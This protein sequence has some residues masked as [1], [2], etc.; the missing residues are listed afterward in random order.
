MEDPEGYEAFLKALGYRESGGNYQLVNTLGY[1]GAY[2][3]G[4]EALADIGYYIPD[5]TPANDWIGR[6]TGKHGVRSWSDFLARGDAQDKAMNEWAAKLWSYAVHPE[7]SLQRY[8]GRKVAGV[9]ISEA[10]IIAGA[11]LVGMSGVAAFLNSGG[12]QDPA[13]P[14]GVNVSAYVTRFAGYKTPFRTPAPAAAVRTGR[15]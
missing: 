12:A 9:R 8:V 15:I 11:H 6:W 3:F 10:S 5:G 14:Y 4:E 13:D 1:L 7:F 2:Q